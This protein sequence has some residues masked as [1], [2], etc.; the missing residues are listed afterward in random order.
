M[1][2]ATSVGLTACGGGASSDSA[3]ARIE[4]RSFSLGADTLSAS[5]GTSSPS[6]ITAQ[7]S[8][9]AV[10]VT[11][12]VY[13]VEAY[14]IP[15][16]AALDTIAGTNPV[17]HRN[18]GV[19]APCADPQTQSCTYSSSRVLSCSL[20]T[21]VTLAPGTYTIV[22]QA[23]YYVDAALNKKCSRLSRALSVS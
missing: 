12:D 20:G 2:L 19:V 5:G 21:P 9:S 17:L 8:A 10:N 13:F 4:L 14:V 22:A 6:N 18:C 11:A 7:W 3:D 23:C 16:G 1:V 15:G